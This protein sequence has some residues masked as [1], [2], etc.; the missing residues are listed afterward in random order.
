MNSGIQKKSLVLRGLLTNLVRYGKIETTPKKAKILKAQADSFFAWLVT[1]IQDRG[2]VDGR[3]EAIRR[4]KAT[5]FTEEEGKK[6][7]DELLPKFV[8][9]KEMGFIQTYKMG[10]RKGDGAESVLIQ[11]M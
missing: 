1:L 2:D 4:I 5:I 9:K 11:I 8:E 7:L 10:S 3:R 6:L